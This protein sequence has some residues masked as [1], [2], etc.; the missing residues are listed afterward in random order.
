MNASEAMQALARKGDVVIREGD[1]GKTMV[2][3]RTDAGVVNLSG[4]T[5]EQLLTELA[6]MCR[7]YPDKEEPRK[8]KITPKPWRHFREERE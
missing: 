7:N 3:L 8:K 4:G 1:D 5:K 2:G 6:R